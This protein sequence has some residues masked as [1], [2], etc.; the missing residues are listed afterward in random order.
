MRACEFALFVSQTFLSEMYWAL[1]HAFR[2]GE[3]IG[4]LH[5]DMLETQR[6]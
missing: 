5:I 6:G 4:P 1:G 2:E 3:M